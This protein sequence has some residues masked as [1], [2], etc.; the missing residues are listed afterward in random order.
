MRYLKRVQAL[1]SNFS[2][3][4]R[5]SWAHYGKFGKATHHFRGEMKT[6]QCAAAF[7]RDLSIFCLF[8]FSLVLFLCRSCVCG[9]DLWINV[10]IISRKNSCSPW[11]IFG[12]CVS[13]VSCVG[14]SR[15][16]SN[17]EK[18]WRFAE[19]VQNFA[20]MRNGF[21]VFEMYILCGDQKFL[22]AFWLSNTVWLYH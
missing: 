22:P 11:F 8:Y 12:L 5:S 18:K 13:K 17:C 2:H 7:R 6:Q 19:T 14:D 1:I 9:N 10:I 20:R 3:W 4:R 21:F 16:I 15:F